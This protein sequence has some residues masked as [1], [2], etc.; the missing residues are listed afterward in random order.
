MLQNTLFLLASMPHTLKLKK[1][2][3]KVD[4]TALAKLINDGDININNLS[5]KNVDSVGTEYF[6]HWKLAAWDLETENHGARQNKDTDGKHCICF[7]TN[8]IQSTS[9]HLTVPPPSSCQH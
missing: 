2:W 9:C 6:P 3:G 4:K 1:N 7:V 8:F 5:T